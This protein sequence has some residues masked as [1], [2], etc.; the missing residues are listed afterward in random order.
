MPTY[1]VMF[2]GENREIIHRDYPDVHALLLDYEQTGIEEDSYT[3]RLHGEPVLRGLI[4][5]MSH[6]KSTV[7][8][9][10]ADAFT[11]LTDEWSK[12]RL[13]AKRT[14]E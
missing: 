5:P 11:V 8:Y 10:T 6:G 14:E 13:S 1:R 7:R 12:T 2:R 4:G 9:E 3:I